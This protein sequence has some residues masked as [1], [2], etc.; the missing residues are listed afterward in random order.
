MKKLGYNI[1][2]RESD[3]KIGMIKNFNLINRMGYYDLYFESTSYLF[4]DAINA[5]LFKIKSKT[6]FR[7]SEDAMEELISKYE[8]FVVSSYLK[9]KLF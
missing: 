2:L 3:E 8:F 7:F 5:Q 6:N 4:F 1:F 9:T